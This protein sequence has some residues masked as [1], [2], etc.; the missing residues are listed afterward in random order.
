L[1]IAGGQAVYNPEPVA[2]F[3]DVFAI[4]EGE[5]VIL[6]IVDAYQAWVNSNGSRQDLLVA[7]GS[8]PG[9]YVPA[10]VTVDYHRDGTIQSV[11]PAHPAVKLPVDKRLLAEFPPPLITFSRPQY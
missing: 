1:V 4:G 11:T 10:L 3:V 2:P 8:I 5:E 6:E 9:V 7:L